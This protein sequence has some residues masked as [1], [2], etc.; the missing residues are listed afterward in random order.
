MRALNNVRLGGQQVKIEF[1]KTKGAKAAPGATQL[2]DAGSAAE[3]AVP[4]GPKVRHRAVLKNLP[5]RGR[6][7]PRSSSRRHTHTHTRERMPSPP[8]YHRTSDR[9][10]CLVITPLR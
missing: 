7:S 2:P 5:V 10:C 4:V 1:A 8:H 9:A 6:S 3:A